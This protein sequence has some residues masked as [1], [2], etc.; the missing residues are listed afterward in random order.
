MKIKKFNENYSD[1]ESNKKELVRLIDDLINHYEDFTNDV[2]PN[3]W[4]TT[5]NH[6]TE[7][8]KMK[9]DLERLREIS[10]SEKEIDW[11]KKYRFNS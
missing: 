6:L 2:S 9:D 4:R 3:F 1:F 5:G 8:K 10:D 7:L 11:V